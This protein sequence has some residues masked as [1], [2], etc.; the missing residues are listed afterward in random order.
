MH[1]TNKILQVLLLILATIACKRQV[2]HTTA[3]CDHYKNTMVLKWNEA[4]SIAVTHVADMPPMTESRVYAMVNVAMHDALNNIVKKYS[5]YAFSGVPDRNADP[6]AAVAQA[7]H[8][9]LVTLVPAQQAFTDSMLN[10]SLAP[11]TAGGAKEKG[12]AVGRSSAAAMLA[13][14]M[15]DGA[16]TAQ[17][18]IVQGTLPGQYQSTPPFTASGFALFPGWGKVMPFSLTAPSQFH[19]GAPYAVNSKE[20]TADYNEI[21]TMGTVTGSNRTPDQTNLGIFWL[22]NI[23]ASWNR[24][25]R[26]LIVQQGLDGWKA[27]YLLSILNMAEADANIAIF[28]AKYSY[29]YWRPITAV[30]LGD[31]DGNPDTQGDAEWNILGKVTP[32]VPDYPSNHAAD[33]GAA[34]ELLKLYFGKDGLAFTTTSTTMPGATR[35][36]TSLSQAA[37]EVSVSRIYVGYHFRHAVIVGEDLGRRIGKWVF[38]KSLLPVK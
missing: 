28:E 25:A 29:N 2:D 10:V 23:P 3:L 18:A 31:L 37:T 34:A 35:N 30:R 12:I 38:E 13:R 11:I 32:P 36:F 5:T 7:A 20:Y 6:D 16:S 22:E 26:T 1:K 17:F 33:G 4:A 8:D 21:K 19:P 24:I 14:R 9:V 27:A 15:N